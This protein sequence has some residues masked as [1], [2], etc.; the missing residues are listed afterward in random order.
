MA[1]SEP[2]RTCRR[3]PRSVAVLGALSDRFANPALRCARPLYDREVTLVKG[4]NIYLVRCFAEKSGSSVWADVRSQ[5]SEADR[6]VVESVIA[7][8]WY[9]LTLQHR[10]FDALEVTFPDRRDDVISD[11]ATFVA[12]HDLT[13][14]HR[15]FLRLRNPAYT[16]EKSA[17]YWRRFYDTGDW[18]V[19][20]TGNHQAHGELTGI[21]DVAPV[22]CRFLNAYI[23]RMFQLAGAT[24]ARCRHTRCVCRGDKVC[25]F[26]GYWRPDLTTDARPSVSADSE[27]PPT[28]GGMRRPP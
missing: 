3:Q 15:L 5:L 20:R 9:P 10:V 17:E 26:E 27:P 13:R 23:T 7:S 22:F 16:L 2:Q 28:S 25:V 14:I 8:G 24:S 12:E 6:A 21:T 1:R 19:V 11:F 18:N 4:S